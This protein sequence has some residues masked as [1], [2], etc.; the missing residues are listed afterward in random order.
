L[1]YFLYQLFDKHTR[2]VAR[3]KRIL[4]F[5]QHHPG[6]G[7]GEIAKKLDLVLATVKK[8]LSKMLL[9]GLITKEGRGKS[10]GYFVV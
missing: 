9:M 8:S 2:S 10:T 1:A 7:S 5:I 4:F 6:T 3:D